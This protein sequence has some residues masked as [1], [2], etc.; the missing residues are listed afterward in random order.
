MM[1]FQYL[2]WPMGLSPT[3]SILKMKHAHVENEICLGY[4]TVMSSHAYGTLKNNL[5]IMWLTIIGMIKI[6]HCL[7]IH[8]FVWII[9]LIWYLIIL[10]S[11][12]LTRHIQVLYFQQMDDNCGYGWSC[13]KLFSCHE[14]SNW[15]LKNTRNKTNDEANNPH[16]L[17]RRL[18]TITCKK[19]GQICHN[20]RSCKSKIAVDKTI[21]NG[22]NKTKKTKTTKGGK[23]NKKENEN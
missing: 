2:M 14:T 9:T 13:T 23:G 4:L 5:E 20:K 17:S 12:H 11:Q 8:W 18:A 21:L 19:Y 10:G 22:G 16:A 3:V 1:I 7:I 6:L 15:S